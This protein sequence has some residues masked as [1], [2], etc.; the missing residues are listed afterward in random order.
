MDV[1]VWLRQLGLGQYEAAFRENAIEADVLPELTEAHLEKLGLP[2]GHRVRLLKAI[3]KLGAPEN[4][5]KPAPAPAQ[6]SDSA[7]RRQ[8]TVMFTDL[9][10]STAL[11][12]RMDPEDLRAIIGAYH[13]CVATTV[14]R[15]DGFVA[16]YMGDG[17][18]IY[19]G[20]PQ[21]HEDDADR[22][23]RAG[24]ALV[25]AVG[26]L[27]GPQPV[28]VRIGLATGLVV[29]GDLVGKGEA[30]ERGIV[31]ETPNLAARL[32][33][34]AEPN[35][36][37]IAEGT[38][39]LL[40]NLFELQ[41]LGRKGLKGIVG[42]T[43]AWAAL[44]AS[45]VASRFEALR[46]TGVTA[47]VGRERELEILARGLADA[48]SQI[49]VIDIVAEPGM[50]KSRLVHEFRQRIGKERAFILSGYCS[51]DGQ[52]TPFLPFIEVVR[53][54]FRVSAG[55]PEKDVA[56]KL[57]LGLTTVGLRSPRNLGLLLHLLGLKVPDGTLTGLDATLIGLRTRELLQHLLE[58][59]CRVSPVVL[60]IEDLY[61]IDSVS[62]E[63][64]GKI[65]DNAGQ[66]PLLIVH[67]RW[68]EYEPAWLDN[69]AVT[70]LH[71]EPLPAGANSQKIDTG[72]SGV[73]PI[74]EGQIASGDRPPSGE[75][76]E[77]F[78]EIGADSRA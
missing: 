11:S 61:W 24:L 59:R 2:L 17:V 53:G 73:P 36:V 56:Q 63:V 15:F 66:L 41:D 44:R 48:L 34:L 72:G 5:S 75:V 76:R 77:P 23:V 62:E 37:I 3:A 13:K 8:V 58:A 6:P 1:G 45:T 50:G 38:R 49:C 67:T 26:S 27:A 21:A 60:V 47:L 39:K 12:A 28:Q 51:P 42:P 19:F 29:V 9:V 52:Q 33:G 40:G 69:E 46:A 35:M 43:R 30:Q 55:E 70:R 4:R 32:Q 57:E 78:A 16:K 74:F 65:V 18:L 68:P 14:A 7:E 31:G 71:L 20:Y 64:L 10:G 54:S 25:D 22:A